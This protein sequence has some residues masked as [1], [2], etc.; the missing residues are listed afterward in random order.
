MGLRIKKRI[1][2]NIGPF[3][4]CS[5]GFAA[6]RQLAKMACK[7]GKPNGNMVWHP[8]DMPGPLLKLTLRDIPGI[9][10]RM[11]QRLVALRHRDDG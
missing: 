8:N 11:E 1:A 4:I 5:I 7:A 6:N 10:E 9:G 2:D 3:I